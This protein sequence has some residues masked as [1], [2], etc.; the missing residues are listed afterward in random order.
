MKKQ[1]LMEL[2]NYL[3]SYSLNIADNENCDLYVQHSFVNKK[4]LGGSK[5]IQY[6]LMVGIDTKDSVVYVL[7]KVSE[8]GSGFSFGSESSSYTQQ[9]TKVYRKVKANQIGL[10]GLAYEVDLNLGT[11]L[12]EIKNIAKNNKY[13]FK[14]VLS[15]SKIKEAHLL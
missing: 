1:V 8:K 5:T 15:L 7:E 6:E 13:K 3:H 14:E 2:E 11:I 4:W 10:D 12:K 9:G